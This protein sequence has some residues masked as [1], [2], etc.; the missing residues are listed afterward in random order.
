MGNLTKD[1]RVSRTPGS[2]GSAGSPGTPGSPAYC[3]QQAVTEAVITNPEG[4]WVYQPP[5]PGNATSGWIYVP[6]SGPAVI[7]YTTRYV[8]VCLPAVPPTPPTPPV[9][10]TG[11]ATTYSF[12]LG[13]NAAAVSAA[14]FEGNA[15]FFFSV[16]ASSVGVVCGLN[17][18]REDNGYATI[19]YAIKCTN[20]YYVVVENGVAKTE[21][22]P[23]TNGTEFTIQRVGDSIAYLEG[24]N[25]F[26]ESAVHWDGRLVA[27]AS[28]YA[29][30]DSITFAEFGE[31]DTVAQRTGAVD[32]AFRELDSFSGDYAASRVDVS[33]PAMTAEAEPPDDF[34]YARFAR[35]SAF[36]GDSS[37]GSASVTF[38]P[39]TVTAEGLTG[40]ET[41]QFALAYVQMPGMT[42]S[43]YGPLAQ[44]LQTF[45]PMIALSA[46]ANYGEV[47]VSMAPAS[48]QAVDYFDIDGVMQLTM[49]WAVEA[50]GT[51]G[52]ANAIRITLALEVE[53]IG[54]AVAAM[55]M[56]AFVLEATG[57]VENYGRAELELP[58][59]DLVA[60]G[61]VANM[62]SAQ[63]RLFP[64]PYARGTGGAVARVQAPAG[65]VVASGTVM[66]VG[67]M[68][69][70]MP[71]GLVSGSGTAGNVGRAELL[72]PFPRL[73]RVGRIVLAPRL[74]FVVRATGHTDVETEYVAWHVNLEGDSK[75]SGREVTRFIDWP[76]N[77]VV[78]FGNTYYG[79]AD[80]GVY[81]IGGDDDNGNPIAWDWH[82]AMSD[83]GETA[84]KTVHAL[85]LGGRLGPTAQVHIAAGEDVSDAAVYSY[86]NPRDAVAQNYR[87]KFGRGV[88][89]RYVAVGASDPDGG[90]LHIESLA[91]EVQKLERSY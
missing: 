13:W 79:L 10:G 46:D 76:F 8:T 68:V 25:V 44:P 32:I 31:A 40:I 41:P 23:F 89:G 22:E 63:L 87:Q 67:S 47:N 12:N 84:R 58:G 26:Y 56:P 33:F 14:S 88:K 16:L 54:H 62:A 36:A 69:L 5:A 82:T 52:R 61:R 6:G 77:Q 55:R 37:T 50:S 4:R 1:I 42:A 64:R 24:G 91:P 51:V 73:A 18:S 48:V 29:A 35:M 80:D 39:M 59:F 86:N 83:L 20:G 27:D 21:P 34:T 65:F 75:D 66:N 28:L 3:Y 57:T 7:T 38:E 15:A 90:A 53:A 43:A 11:D 9:E 49:G 19:D 71:A 30:G 2:A 72:M 45:A 81:A 17:R 60:S 74:R 85:I 78:R 70:T